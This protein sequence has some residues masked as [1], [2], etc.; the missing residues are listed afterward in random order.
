MI[1]YNSNYPLPITELMLKILT[2]DQRFAKSMEDNQFRSL[3]NAFIIKIFS[4][5]QDDDFNDLQALEKEFLNVYENMVKY[6]K[7]Y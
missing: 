5:S 3:F 4:Y 1:E 7:E 2:S 6:S